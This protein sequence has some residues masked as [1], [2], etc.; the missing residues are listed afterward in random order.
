[1][2]L[3]RLGRAVTV[4]HLALKIFEDEPAAIGWLS[5]SNEALAGQT[6]IMLCRTDVEEKQV[7]RLLQAMACG[8]AA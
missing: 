2:T 1:M 5:H 7:L 8:G 6:P 3:D 4:S